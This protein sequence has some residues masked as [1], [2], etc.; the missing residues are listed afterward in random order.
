MGHHNMKEGTQ[1]AKTVQQ[2][3]PIAEL[4]ASLTPADLGIFEPKKRGRVAEPNPWT[5]HVKAS[6]Q[7]ADGDGLGK[8]F[9]IPIAFGEQ[10][11]VVAFL[12]RAAREQT[13]ALSVQVRWLDDNA[14]D[15]QIGDAEKRAACRGRLAFRTM[16][17]VPRSRGSKGSEG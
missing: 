12:R 7:N 4:L 14:E 13:P 6:A 2:S 11:R 10:S 16:P 1:V 15:A 9:L 3:D 8:A 17:L 5:N